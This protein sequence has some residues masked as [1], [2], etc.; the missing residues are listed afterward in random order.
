MSS[1]YMEHAPVA[2]AVVE[3]ATH[4]IVYA[5]AEFRRVSGLA[6][7]DLVGTSFADLPRRNGSARDAQAHDTLPGEE[8]INVL[9]HVR[10][11]H[12]RARE[13]AIAGNGRKTRAGGDSN[14]AHTEGE[15]G[16]KDFVWRCTAWPVRGH[17]SGIDRL[18]VELRP[19]QQEHLAVT[20][21]RNIAERML[22]SA[23]REQTLS[24]ENVRLASSAS[25]QRVVAE[26]AQSSAERAQ[27]R[28]EAAQHEAE[29][30]NSAKARF[31]ANMSHELRTPL[32][33]I[34]GYAQLIELGLRGP[35]T[36]AQIH[37]LERIRLSQ[38]HLLGLINTILNYSKL[39]AGHMLYAPVNLSLDESLIAAESLIDPQLRARGLRYQFIPCA[40]EGTASSATPIIVRADPEKLQQILLN[41]LTNAIKYTDP[42]GE[43]T[44]ACR[45]A[46]CIAHVSVSD[47][48]RGIPRDQMQSIFH[49]FVQVGRDLSS[50]ESGV[51]LG[52]AISRELAL[53]MGGDLTVESILGKGSTFTLRLP[54]VV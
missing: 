16:R 20:R 36:P 14:D 34:G 51:G 13:I 19:A 21:Q 9:D 52:L 47:T 54:L 26:D 23:L 30:A 6:E 53:G 38:A 32:N 46:D 24:A 50:T 4:V 5:N 10:R 48:G 7:S 22:L 40:R 44:L 45:T 29:A 49:P 42:G 35:V 11:E 25:A 3:G 1:R 37:D 28:A 39:E 12:V 43:I 8:L 31:L 27:V 2:M 15:S 18:V 41:L 33:A 17:R